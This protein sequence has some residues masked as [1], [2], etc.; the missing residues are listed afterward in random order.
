MLFSSKITIL[1]I[2]Y[3]FG[4]HTRKKKFV[5]QDVANFIPMV[6]RL[7]EIV[8]NY[9]KILMKMSVSVRFSGRVCKV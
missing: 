4:D 3:R 6:S 8:L 5:T 1:H 9:W 7:T 2:F